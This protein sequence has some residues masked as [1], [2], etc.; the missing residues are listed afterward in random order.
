MKLKYTLLLI[1]LI[2]VMSA[3]N[4]SDDVVDIFTGKTYKLTNFFHSNGK[5]SLEDYLVGMNATQREECL[6]RWA[7]KDN[8]TI[9]FT[10]AEIEGD[11]IGEYGGRAGNSTISGKWRANGDNNSFSTSNQADP[12]SNEDVLGRAFVNA[13]KNAYKYEGDTAGNLTIYFKE[14]N[15]DKYLLL[16]GN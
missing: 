5:Q 7:N 12:G 13:L 9:K 2:P 1:L 10:G 3:C 11:V 16:Y 6:K 15:T 14:N 4:Q 8:Y